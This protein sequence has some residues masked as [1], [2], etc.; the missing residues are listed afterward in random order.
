MPDLN[1]INKR[2]QFLQSKDIGWLNRVTKAHNK[3]IMNE[4]R[5][6]YFEVDKQ[7]SALYRR[8][9][10]LSYGEM[11]K[12]NRLVN[13]N[14]SIFQQLKKM[15]NKVRQ[16]IYQDVRAEFKEAYY[17]TGYGVESSLQRDM[18]F[19][20]L[21]V[22]TVSNS[23][24]K[25][26]N[27]QTLNPTLNKNLQLINSDIQHTI[28][29][30]LLQGHGYGKMAKGIK[31][32][33]NRGFNDAVRVTRTEGHRAR[34]IGRLEGIEHA[35]R[36]GVKMKRYWISAFQPG[37]RDLHAGM[38]GKFAN[39]NKIFNL[40]GGLSTEAPGLVGVAY[41]DINCLCH[42]GTQ[43]VGFKPEYKRLRGKGIIKRDIAYKEWKKMKKIR[44]KT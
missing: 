24:L 36:K 31:E 27:F 25:R 44:I 17:R 43:V 29:Q 26:Y 12:Y 28:N 37:T 30:G 42:V 6:A 10:E 8:F 13:L 11:A 4:Y 40:P 41:W 15:D 14:K 23:L 3:L 18:H 33:F 1:E 16:I 2:F 34:E 38:D 9:P 19:S 35:E 32:N 20:S 7:I 21:N 39:K 5:S 22:N